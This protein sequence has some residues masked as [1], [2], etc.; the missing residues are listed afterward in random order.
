MPVLEWLERRGIPSAIAALFCILVF[1][2]I[3]NIAIAAIV[4]PATDFFQLLPSRITR[5]QH[6]LSP[7]LDLYS[8]LEKS[9]NKMFRQIASTPVRQP[10][11]AAVAR[12][13]RSW[14]SPRRRRRR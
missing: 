10:Q 1:L 6:N 8:T 12:P 7:L 5:I 3:A 2:I 13:A 4:V 14:N 9:V 11:T